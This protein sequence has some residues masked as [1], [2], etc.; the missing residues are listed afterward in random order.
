VADLAPTPSPKPLAAPVAST[1]PHHVRLVVVTT[2][3]ADVAVP[4][5]K[6]TLIARYWEPR[7]S[8]WVEVTVES[9]EHAIRRFADEGGWVLRQQQMLESPERHEL[10]FEAKV[11][12]PK[13]PSA[14]DVLEE[15]GL[16]REDAEDLVHRVEE[17]V[18]S[19]DDPR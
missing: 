10:I 1:E 9:V 11:K 7:E 6:P 18:E 5:A 17:R 13:R 2:R 4:E 8:R 19:D 16:T 15:V 14:V 12:P 3:P